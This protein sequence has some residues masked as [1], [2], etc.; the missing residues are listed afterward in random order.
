MEKRVRGTEKERKRDQMSGLEA[1]PKSPERLRLTNQELEEHLQG[2]RQE[3][4]RSQRRLADMTTY[5]EGLVV[6]LEATRRANQEYRGERVYI[7]IISYIY[8]YIY[9]YI[10]S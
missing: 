5:S 6:D 7:I 4:Q 9:I 8:I 3:L 10:Y 1:K 2:V